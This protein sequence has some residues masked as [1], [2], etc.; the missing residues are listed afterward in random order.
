MSVTASLGGGVAVFLTVLSSDEVLMH[1]W[2][3]RRQVEASWVDEFLIFF[4]L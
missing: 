2:R 4:K 3:R 1:Y